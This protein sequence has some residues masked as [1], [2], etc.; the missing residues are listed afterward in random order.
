MTMKY[1]KPAKECLHSKE[2]IIHS[3]AH[4]LHLIG[5]HTP[6]VMADPLIVHTVYLIV[7]R[8]PTNSG[9]DMNLMPC[10]YK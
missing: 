5:D 1:I 9:E 4:M 3:I 6:L 10:L 8:T 7:R 2:T